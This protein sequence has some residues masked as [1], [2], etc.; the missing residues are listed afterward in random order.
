M[1]TALQS[2]LGTVLKI[3]GKLYL[4]V[5]YEFHRGGRGVTTVNL[6]LKNLLEGGTTDRQFDSEVKL[7]DVILDRA[8]FEFLYESG[9]TYA[10]MNNTTYEQIEL[11]EDDIGDSR[12]FLTE[13]LMVDV[14]QYNEKFVGISLPQTV[15]LTVV[16]A[17]PG[18]K[19]NT[20]D[21]KII[22]DAVMNTGLRVKIPGFVEQG[23]DIIVNTDTG[24]YQERAK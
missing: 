9:G 19:G 10:F 17:D 11:S 7:E 21:G 6:R 18:V 20:A 2:K 8:K 22:K 14:Q 24:E 1:K 5:R 16:E 13:G 15:R 12:F 4:V 23:E 3:D